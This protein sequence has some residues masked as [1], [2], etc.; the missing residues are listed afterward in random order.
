MMSYICEVVDFYPQ[1]TIF[2]YNTS[3][4][5]PTSPSCELQKVV[6]KESHFFLVIFVFIALEGIFA[7]PVTCRHGLMGAAQQPR[8]RPGPHPADKQPANHC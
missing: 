1:F 4:K 2:M 8:T 6:Q 3:C 5:F 7:V